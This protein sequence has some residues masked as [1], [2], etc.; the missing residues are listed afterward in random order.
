MRDDLGQRVRVQRKGG[1]AVQGELW[2]CVL[3]AGEVQFK[4]SELGF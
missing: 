4:K 2:E 1:Q 3:C